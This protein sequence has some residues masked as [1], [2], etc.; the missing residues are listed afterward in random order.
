MTDLEIMKLCAEALSK[1]TKMLPS[2]HGNF[3]VLCIEVE[4]KKDTWYSYNPL[5]DDAQAMALDSVLID[6]TH[7]ISFHQAWF[8]RHEYPSGLLTFEFHAD[9]T[10]PENRRRARC[11]CVAKMQLSKQKSAA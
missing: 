9:M 10:Q 5:Y 11:E 1:K 7:S 3:D 8:C 4:G 2:M 6:E